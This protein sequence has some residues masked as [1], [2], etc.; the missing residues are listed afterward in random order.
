MSNR[1][2]LI[3]NTF[4]YGLS[5][6]LEYFLGLIIT[7]I[8]ARSLGAEQYGVYSFILWLS[9][10]GVA[11]LSD[12]LGVTAIRFLAE[13]R[14]SGS[15]GQVRPLVAWLLR[16]L[17]L[18]AIPV[19]VLL[20]GVY[21]MTADPDMPGYYWVALLVIA[22]FIPK[23][24]NIFYVNV[25]K[26][27]EEY[28]TQFR[29]N[30]FI[31]PFNLIAVS[32][33]A[34]LGGGVR[35]FVAAYLLVSLAYAV[36]SWRLVGAKLEQYPPGRASEFA[37]SGQLEQVTRSVKLMTVTLFLGFIVEKQ[38]EV[39]VLNFFDMAKDAGLY[40]A[41]YILGVSAMG[42]VPGVL[43]GIILP[44]MARAGATGTEAQA[45]KYREFSRYLVLLAVP[46]VCYGVALSREIIEL[47]FGA[48]YARSAIA[49]SI[50]LIASGM[51]IMVHSAN[52]VLLTKDMQHEMLKGVA[53]GA[54]INIAIDFIAIPQYG[55]WGALAGF[56]TTLVFISAWNTRLASK[57]LTT[58]LEWAYYFKAFAVGAV[59]AA[60][61]LALKSEFPAPV[62]IFIGGALYVALFLIGLWA[63]GL[64]R[65]QDRAVLRYLGARVPVLKGW[66][67]A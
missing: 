31:N 13:L 26:G 15:E 67:T 10:F 27:I 1:K 48:E 43:S 63:A 32:V 66:V 64:L 5:S 47:V 30:L 21:W 56:I 3:D 2:K 37:A 7:T 14:G 9:A 11:L 33:V 58:R 34:L 12:G 62:S 6:Y 22:S 16:L 17:V 55:M 39:F 24:I 25:A 41:G 4:F 18:A 19:V 61:F 45:E 51:T 38:L 8:I 35:E 52:S 57:A 28:T 36:A 50:V 42:L 60:P 65:E 46:L 53:L 49:F 44:V 23:A 29:I 40:N 20:L 59:L 54:V